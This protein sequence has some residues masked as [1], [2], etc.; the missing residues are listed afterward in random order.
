MST[1]TDT[2]QDSW[3]NVYICRPEFHTGASS[4]SPYYLFHLQTLMAINGFSA[5]L[6]SSFSSSLCRFLCIF[7][8]SP[9]SHLS[10]Q[11]LLL[12]T[13][14]ST[15]SSTCQPPR[16]HSSSHSLPLPLLSSISPTSPELWGIQDRQVAVVTGRAEFFIFL[17]CIFFPGERRREREAGEHLSANWCI[18]QRQTERTRLGFRVMF[19]QCCC[20]HTYL[21]VNVAPNELQNLLRP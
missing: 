10:V 1:I 15:F 19:G 3:V 5:W 4:S 8:V 20:L 16:S 21:S 7:F 9:S 2:L 12:P 17:F 6:S 18:W 11:P 14:P 13:E